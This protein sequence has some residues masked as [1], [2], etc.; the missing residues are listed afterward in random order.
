MWRGAV[1]K[2]KGWGAVRTPHANP[3]GKPST[4]VIPQSP[5]SGW[6]TTQGRG[7]LK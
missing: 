1:L 3:G 4:Q 2:Y 6:D 7:S 5:E